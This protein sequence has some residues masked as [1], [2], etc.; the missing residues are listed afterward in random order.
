MRRH[1]CQW[2]T[3]YPQNPLY[4]IL[5]THCVRKRGFARGFASWRNKHWRDLYLDVFGVS[6]SY[7]WFL[8]T[9]LK[10]FENT[11]ANCTMT[12]AT[13]LKCWGLPRCEEVG[14]WVE[15]GITGVRPDPGCIRCILNFLLDLLVR[16]L[17]KVWVFF[18]AVNSMVKEQHHSHKLQVS[19]SLLLTCEI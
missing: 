1:C 9:K 3:R 16:C 10:R 12:V 5:H 13:M 7:I 17:E 8:L 14:G 2:M 11:L 6:Q 4:E 19:S 18:M 15:S